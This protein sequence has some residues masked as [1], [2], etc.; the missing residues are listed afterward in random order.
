MLSESFEDLPAPF[1]IYRIFRD[2]PHDEQALHRLRALEDVCIN[3]FYLI[4]VL[5]ECF[6]VVAV[7]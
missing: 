2:S 3:D 7:S 4:V 6:R 1:A 5:P